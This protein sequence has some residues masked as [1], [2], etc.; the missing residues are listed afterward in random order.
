ML[1]GM[2]ALPALLL[3][4]YA[5]LYVGKFLPDPLL[6]RLS[7]ALLVVVALAAI[8]SPYLT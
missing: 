6:R 3:G 1:L 8:I 5:G 4:L 7:L 2:A